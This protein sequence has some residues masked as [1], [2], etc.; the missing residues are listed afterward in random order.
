MNWSGPRPHRG[1]RSRGEFRYEN[2]LLPVLPAATGVCSVCHTFVTDGWDRCYQCN[3]AVRLLPSTA[4]CVS[5]IALAVKG[6]Q[7]AHDL[8]NYK[9]GPTPLRRAPRL[10]LAAVL[11]RFLEKHEQ[12]LATAAGV[13]KFPVVTTVPSTRGRVEPPLDAIVGSLVGAT[14]NRFQPLL[15]AQAGDSGGRQFDAERFELIGTLTPG[16]SILLIDDTFTTGSRVQCASA[17]LKA[18]GSGPVGVLC[19]GRHFSLAHSDDYRP[20]TE[21]YYKAARRA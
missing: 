10:G 13:A 8:R 17:A 6:E 19:I 1:H 5:I 21:R 15:N 16:T 7:F 18:S 2:F 12:C 14:A 20:S 11:W 9:D 4:D 3:Q